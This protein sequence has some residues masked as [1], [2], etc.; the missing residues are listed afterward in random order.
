MSPGN[1]PDIQELAIEWLKDACETFGVSVTIL[2][3]REP[4]ITP[5]QYLW[6]AGN[7]LLSMIEGVNVIE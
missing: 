6:F 3:Y 4:T 7:G 2:G 5:E 1:S